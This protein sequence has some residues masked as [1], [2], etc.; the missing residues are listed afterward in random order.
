M[1]ESETQPVDEAEVKTNEPGKS[2]QLLLTV[3]LVLIVGG[4]V[5]ALSMKGEYSTFQLTGQSRIKSGS[6]A[7][8]FTFPDLTGKEVGLS[9]YRGKVVFLNI[10]ATWCPPCVD[11]MPSMEKL[12]KQFKGEQFE[13]IAVSIDGEGRKVVAPFMERLNLTFPA[14]LDRKGKIKNIY[15]VTGIPESFIID[16]NGIIVKKVIG[17]LDWAKPDVS[18]F[19]KDL[20][21]GP[22]T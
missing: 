8:D 6:Q 18:R 7:P 4:I 10:W 20:I 19:F 13:I 5:I 9:D 17:P 12:Y 16:K 3:L 1:T 22:R 15:G 2:R 11:E 14:L 21:K